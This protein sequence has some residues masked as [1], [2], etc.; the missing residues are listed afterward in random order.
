VGIHKKLLFLAPTVDDPYTLLSLTAR[1]AHYL[2]H[3]GVA[4]ITI[5]VI[6]ALTRPD[7]WLLGARPPAGMDP[8][9]MTKVNSIIDRIDFVSNESEIAAAAAASEV[10]GFWDVRARSIEPWLGF[11]KRFRESRTR[12][13]ID[14]VRTR[15][16]GRGFADIAALWAAGTRSFDATE[17]TTFQTR[18]AHLVG[19]DAACLLGSGPSARGALDVDLGDAVRIVCNTTILDDEL[20]AHVRPDIVTF[21]DPIFH[22]GPS[23]YAHRF[24]RTLAARA[25]EYDFTIV[26]LEHFAELLRSQVPELADRIVGVRLGQVSWPQNFDLR[27]HLAVRPFPNI[28]TMLMLPLAATFSRRLKLIGFDGRGQ[29]ESYF[30]R[31]GATV[32][33]E[34]ELT[35][36]RSVHPGFFNLDYADYYGQHVAALGQ[37]LL[38]LELRGR[39]IEP[40]TPSS[41]LPLKRRKRDD[42]APAGGA[43]RPASPAVVSVTPDWTGDFGHFGPWERAVR[44]AARAAGYHYRSLG[45]RALPPRESWMVPTF[46]HGTVDDERARIP[47]FAQDLRD[48]LAHSIGDGASAIVCFYAASVW[49][50]PPLLELACDRP[51]TTFVV[52]L[53]RSHAEIV[54]GDPDG[55][56]IPLQLL[57]QCIDAAAGTN[58]HIC[59]D[60][61]ALIGDLEQHTGRSAWQWP[62]V[63]IA[64]ADLLQRAAAG[65]NASPVH[66]V[67]PVHAQT[68]RGFPLLAGL[69]GRFRHS[70]HSGRIAFSARMAAQPFVVHGET[71]RHAQ[72]FE[73]AGGTLVRGQLSDAQYAAM[74]GG[75]HV[76]LVP[77]RHDLFRTR[78]SGVVLDAIAAG[79]PVV[80]TQ[81]TWAGD[82]V[83]RHGAGSTFEDGDVDSFEFAVRRVLND[84]RGFTAAAQ[85][86]RATVVADFHPARLV[87][88][89]AGLAAAQRQAPDR[90][91]V[92]GLRIASRLAATGYWLDRVHR[93]DERLS[94]VVYQDDTQRYLQNTM[95]QLAVLRVD[96]AKTKRELNKLRRAAAPAAKSPARQPT[97]TPLA[98]PLSHDI[99]THVYPR[100]DGAR[101]DEMRLVASILQPETMPDAVMVDVGAHV[102]SAFRPFHLAGWTI[103]A[104][105]PDPRH[106]ELLAD[107]HAGDS[108]VRLDTRAISDASGR[109][110]PFYVSRESS[111]I[112]GLSAFRD[113]H[114]EIGHVETLALRDVEGLDRVDL[115]KIDTEGHEK[116][117]LEGFPWDRIRPRVIVAEFEDAK[118]LRHGYATDDLVT[119]LHDLG[120]Q[121]WLS[122]WHPIVKYGIQH[123]W[124][125]L[126]NADDAKPDSA[127]W[128]N[129][130]AF[131]ESIGADVIGR[132]LAETL[133]FERTS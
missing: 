38:D 42:Q 34:K 89:L 74:V 62:M 2:E 57:T 44:A 101:L 104:F 121:V 99:A 48:G 71:E 95:D 18:T 46:T 76:V 96:A 64:D 37:M 124:H 126:L 119:F 133:T 24:H 128:G 3:V 27:R 26:T 116:F 60:T 32:Q 85:Q 120:Y 47:E 122:E 112:S 11:A 35:E 67:A 88:F 7:R 73:S 4:R 31:H 41:M 109:K 51:G 49:H 12:F 97:T 125:R 113:T 92:E 5:P 29:S 63:M 16:D 82:L 22:F 43:D 77:Y 6:P 28:L 72:M 23:T 75:A 79:K 103:H 81:G 69:A 13:S 39:T 110:V 9:V 50:L 53:M 93:V 80:A 45:S 40:I 78:T 54:A 59:L 114:I 106:A 107:R 87:S 20:M 118:T 66:L 117:V 25:R 84:L 65:V 58:V 19:A 21:A 61:D 91:Q 86:A 14:W 36:I 10:I 8:D 127:A 115:L 68:G 70:M 131:R 94:Y 52:N 105:E 15:T 1:L 56:N 100:D 98:D 90:V 55:T 102:G 33:F 83:E 108:R 132:A 17:V 130:I 30:W 111:G 123:Q 129:L